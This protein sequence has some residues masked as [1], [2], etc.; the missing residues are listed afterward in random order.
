MV[1]RLDLAGAPEVLTILSGRESSVRKLDA[2]RET[3]G[4]K[5]SQWYPALTNRPWPGTSESDPDY[6]LWEAAE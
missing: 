3:V 2:L 6:D 5:P 4:E 1:V